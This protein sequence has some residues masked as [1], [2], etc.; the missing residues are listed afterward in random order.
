[1]LLYFG[2]LN[3]SLALR[4]KATRHL[5]NSKM[6]RV[7]FLAFTAGLLLEVFGLLAEETTG[8]QHAG[9]EWM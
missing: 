9:G 7:C 8:N 6:A 2:V 4:S 3:L 1:M 5:N